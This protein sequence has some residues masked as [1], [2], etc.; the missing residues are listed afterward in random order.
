MLAR[1]PAGELPAGPTARPRGS[2]LNNSS[3]GCVALGWAG[4]SG[5]AYSRT[6]PNRA[7]DLIWEEREQ[8]GSVG[9]TRS[10]VVQAG[11]AIADAEGLDA[12]SIRRVAAELGARPMSLYTHVASRDD[13]VALML[14]EVSG[15]LLVGEPLP[16]DW[17]TAM[18]LIA[19]R[20]RDAYMAHPWMLRVF[21]T[22]ARVGPN[23]LR[24]AEQ[25]ASAVAGLGIDPTDSWT[26]LRVV[27]EWT[28][29]Y[30]L[31]VITLR[32][33]EQLEAQLRQADPAEYPRM[34]QI[35]P[36]GRGKEHDV[37]FDVALDVVLD[38]IAHHFLSP[39]ATR[40]NR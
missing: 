24:R 19:E 15:E 39:G 29:G 34:S 40:E 13:L 2:R 17:R 38:G 12:V 4:E 35:F 8:V 36:T 11:L 33:D 7:S 28:M 37:A 26:A 20:T 3:P 32:E 30:A 16:R 23:Q 18:R 21:V 25:S 31:H 22:G 14:N 10:R 1:T 5:G 27:H 6:V 9:L